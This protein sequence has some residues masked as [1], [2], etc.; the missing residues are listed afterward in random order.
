MSK[1]SAKQRYSQLMDWLPTFNR[2]QNK[3]TKQRESR[4]DYYKKKNA[5]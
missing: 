4:I 5:R 2:K 1:I 3:V